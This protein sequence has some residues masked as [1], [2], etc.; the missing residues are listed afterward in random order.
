[1][2]GSR[3]V[4]KDEAWEGVVNDKSRNMPDGSNLYHYLEVT[5]TDGKTKKIRVDRSLWDSLNP[6]DQIVKQAGSDP[7]K[8]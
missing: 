4:H 5:F 2:F 3:K 1:M 8:K 7:V 6:G